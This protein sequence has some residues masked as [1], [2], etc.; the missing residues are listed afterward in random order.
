MEDLIKK[1]A[2]KFND[3]NF[4]L[5]EVG[6]HVRDAILNRESHDID[7][8]TNARPNSFS[9]SFILSGRALVVRSMS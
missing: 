1:I 3:H 5:W 7:L 9:S 6:G 4:E 8:T 2:K